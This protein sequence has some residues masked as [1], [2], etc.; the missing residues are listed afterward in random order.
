MKSF[1]RKAGSLSATV[2]AIATPGD[3]DHEDEN[4]HGKDNYRGKDEL[5]FDR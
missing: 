1:W 4:R 2:A 3:T 5:N